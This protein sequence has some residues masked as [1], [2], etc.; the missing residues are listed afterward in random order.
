M[1]KPDAVGV[2]LLLSIN[3]FLCLSIGALATWL[4]LR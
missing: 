3:N 4:A 1:T 2:A